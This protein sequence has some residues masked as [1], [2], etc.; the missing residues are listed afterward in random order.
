[1]NM[2][3]G[4]WMGFLGGHG[5]CFLLDMGNIAILKGRDTQIDMGGKFVRQ[6][7]STHF[8][9]SPPWF[10]FFGHLV[11]SVLPASSYAF[12][13]LDGVVNPYPSSRGWHTGPE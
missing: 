10:W 7:P 12:L 13:R 6:D 5:R 2:D 9:G 1:M 3:G 11:Q 8:D 4:W